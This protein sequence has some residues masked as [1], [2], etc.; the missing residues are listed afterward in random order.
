M[1]HSKLIVVKLGEFSLAERCA[2]ERLLDFV[3]F[4]RESH[5]TNSIVMDVQAERD[6]IVERSL[7]LVRGV[8]IDVLSALH[9]TLRVVDHCVDDAIANRF[10]DDELDILTR[11]KTELLL[12]VREADA[13]VGQVDTTQTGLDD[14]CAK[15]FENE[16]SENQKIK[17][18]KK[19]KRATRTERKETW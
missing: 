10:G 13:R 7:R 4:R 6:A 11:F 2:L 8:D 9:V 15:P 14:V 18:S 5:R 16:V 1:L 19:S 3:L 12:H 17:K